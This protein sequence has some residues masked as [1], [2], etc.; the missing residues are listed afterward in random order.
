MSN[1][2]SSSVPHVEDPAV[3]IEIHSVL[4]LHSTELQAAIE[5]VNKGQPVLL[6][7]ATA[8]A[9]AASPVKARP[10]IR[11]IWTWSWT[12]IDLVTV[13]AG[14]ASF[15]AMGAVAAPHTPWVSFVTAALGMVAA[16]VAKIFDK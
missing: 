5:A 8:R 15:G 10:T 4:N 14:G 3:R 12:G 2:S 16:R 13:L 11:T 6:V 9:D 7:P 1:K